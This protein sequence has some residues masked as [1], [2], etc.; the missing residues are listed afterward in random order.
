M[1]TT[2][3][4]STLDQRKIAMEALSTFV[5]VRF[6]IRGTALDMLTGE[7]GP[8]SLEIRDAGEISMVVEGHDSPTL[9][10]PKFTQW[11]VGEFRALALERYNSSPETTPIPDL[12][13]L[14]P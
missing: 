1:T 4:P 6:M 10:A 12:R 5:G 8:I 3:R 13:R 14:K 7:I 11:V 2:A 9:H